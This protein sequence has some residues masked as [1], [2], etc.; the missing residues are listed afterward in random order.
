[1]S[2]ILDAL[3][4]ADRERN[5]QSN[6]T[7]LT[8]VNSAS[9]P[10]VYPVKRWTIE[11]LII[12]AIGVFALY[13]MRDNSSS[14]KT[15]E[16]VPNVVSSPPEEN[17]MPKPK[18]VPASIEVEPRQSTSRTAPKHTRGITQTDSTI[19]HSANPTISALYDKPAAER[20]GEAVV[21]EKIIQDS[22]PSADEFVDNTQSILESISALSQFSPKFRNS[23]PN[24]EYTVH[25]Y[26][27]K[28]GFVI[29]NGRKYQTGN[30]VN[31]DLRVV[32]ILKESVVLDFR[33][34]QF[35]LLA[36]N[37]WVNYR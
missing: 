24:L 19:T 28:A 2:L 29:L 20:L 13:Q 14:T 30:R 9:S 5:V 27:E 37:S 26:S 35:R 34:K 32:A 10:K 12:I 1:M 33:G 17:F 25:V 4:R 23:I 18:V 6:D 21:K 22:K 15:S 31:A 36:L 8:E 11:A 7:L 16:L 3:N